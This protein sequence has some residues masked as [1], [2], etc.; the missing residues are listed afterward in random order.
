MAMV[1]FR[2]SCGADPSVAAL[3][4]CDPRSAG[5]TRT[6]VGCSVLKATQVPTVS[7]GR[8]SFN[9]SRPLPWHKRPGSAGK[10]NPSS[11]AP[12][13]W[14][15]RG[16]AHKAEPSVMPERPTPPSPHCGESHQMLPALDERSWL[17]PRRADETQS[18]GTAGTQ[19][20]QAQ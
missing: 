20:C 17:G 19:S 13:G 3:G 15:F 9:P 2:A 10:G 5:G 18:L 7:P 8:L 14:H 16:V 12:D 1:R 4:I 6:A 11:E